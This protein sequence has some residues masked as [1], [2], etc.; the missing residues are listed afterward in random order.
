[1][2]SSI[3]LV[4]LLAVL[5]L[6][7]SATL[8]ENYSLGVRRWGSV[9]DGSLPPP[10]SRE[11][12]PLKII[13][14][15]AIMHG[16]KGL[17]VIAD[18]LRTTTGS[19]DFSASSA[20]SYGMVAFPTSGTTAVWTTSPSAY[21]AN[22]GAATTSV[23][24]TT[25]AVLSSFSITNP[26]SGTWVVTFKGSVSHS[27]TSGSLAVA[28]YVGSTQA[29]YSETFSDAK[30]E[31]GTYSSMFTSSILVKGGTNNIAIY[32]YTNSGNTAT[33]TNGLMTTDMLSF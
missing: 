5:A 26:Y 18:S 19:V 33:I 25:Y 24:S 11:Q 23:T 14:A 13:N 1:M 3:S 31:A 6:T 29:T 4:L 30:A 10:P 16:K 32:A 9:F 22:V 7:A 8:P 21:H 27:T 2:K 15:T 17:T 28:I 12:P 20:P